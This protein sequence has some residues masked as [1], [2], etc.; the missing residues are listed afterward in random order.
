MFAEKRTW[1]SMLLELTA[2]PK[3]TIYITKDKHNHWKQMV[4]PFDIIKGLR[5]G[6]SWCNY[7][8][9]ADAFAFYS[10]SSN[11]VEGY[12]NKVYVN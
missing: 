5:Y 12:L 2:E 3:P 9:V 7:F 6:Q 11:E 8:D 4:L 10:R 1:Q